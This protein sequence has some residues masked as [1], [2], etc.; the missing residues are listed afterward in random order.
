M[1]VGVREFEAEVNLLE[2]CSKNGA[3]PCVMKAYKPASCKRRRRSGD[4]QL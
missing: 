1:V 4:A 3:G 2:D